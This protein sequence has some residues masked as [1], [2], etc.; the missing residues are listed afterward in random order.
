MLYAQP[1]INATI[2]KTRNPAKATQ[3]RPGGRGDSSCGGDR[4]DAGVVGDL[5]ASPEETPA[6]AGGTER[7]LPHVV[8]EPSPTRVESIDD[9]VTGSEAFLTSRLLELGLPA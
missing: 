4:V 8:G 9:E 5:E 2:C 7:S 1:T 6:P 3:P